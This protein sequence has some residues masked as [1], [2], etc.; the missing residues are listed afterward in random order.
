MI[1]SM[2]GYGEAEADTEWGSFRLEIKTVNHR[3]LN[4]QIRLPHGFAQ[5]ERLI[6]GWIRD[7]FFRGHV[8]FS[9]SVVPSE[10]AAADTA[11]LDIECARAYAEQLGELRDAL[12]IEGGIEL[13]HLLRFGDIFKKID[14][15]VDP[16]E[17][18]PSVL[19]ELTDTALKAVVA[20]RDEEGARLQADLEGRLDA[21]ASQLDVVETR[22]P[23]RLDSERE[24][25]R[26]AIAELIGSQDVDEDR[27]AREIA[28]LSEKWDIN[29]ELVRFRAHIEMFREVLG[30]SAVEGVG[31]RLGFLVQEMHREANTI[32]SKANDLEIG[33]ASVGLKE[34]VE[35]LREQLENVE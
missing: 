29:E 13:A 7:R 33:H 21:M 34:E 5:F 9:L 15:R 1:R 30:Q 22:A 12:G 28:Y 19:R 24:R 10:D 14:T 18:D 20:H 8:S 31:K 17:V 4:P 11:G 26:A 3:F 27:I 23:V 35:R 2:T 32:G 6:Q 25:L 16:S